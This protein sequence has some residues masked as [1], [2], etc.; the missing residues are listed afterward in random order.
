VSSDVLCEHLDV[1]PGA[2]RVAISRLRALVGP[3]AGATTAVR[4]WRSRGGRC[5]G[6]RRCWRRPR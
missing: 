4:P 2:P 5:R 1:S 3:D 6:G